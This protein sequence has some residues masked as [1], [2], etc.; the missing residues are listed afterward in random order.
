MKKITVFS[1]CL[2]LALFFSASLSAFAVSEEAGLDPS[3]DMS[4]TALSGREREDFNREIASDEAFIHLVTTAA[5]HKE[6]DVSLE[7]VHPDKCIKL[8]G[9]KNSEKDLIDY[10]CGTYEE[11]GKI[12]SIMSDDYGVLVLYVNENNE[13]VDSF[14]F[15]RKE[16]LP[17]AQ[18]KNGWVPAGSGSLTS[19]EDVLER[20]S[21]EGSLEKYV[22]GLGLKNT[23]RLRITSAI[24]YFPTCI[25]F[26]QENEEFLVPLEDGM[27]G[28]QGSQ[29]YKVSDIVETY[30]KPILE[31]Q[32]EQAEEYRKMN[33][34][35]EYLPAGAPEFPDNLPLQAT[36]DLNTYFENDQ[37]AGGTTALPERRTDD[38]AATPVRQTAEAAVA[39]VSKPATDS[40]PWILA[41]GFVILLLAGGI[42][43]AVWK[44]KKE[45][46]KL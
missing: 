19:D 46:P 44:R 25:Y 40:A 27:A 43:F 32:I 8:Y 30:L 10:L 42:G 17:G 15:T 36:V 11:T 35:S 23:S 16:N 4:D 29:V 33:P 41:A 28:I 21:D 38:T 26:V 34:D 24:P 2:I 1:F 12:E 5:E 14:A 13:Y 3:V 39:D 18:D 22:T 20:Y 45:S 31:F 7:G 6:R 37:T 9:L